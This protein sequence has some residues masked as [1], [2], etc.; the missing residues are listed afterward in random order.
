MLLFGYDKE[1]IFEETRFFELS[2]NKNPLKITHYTVLI[3][4]RADT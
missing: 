1:F 2:Q 3:A 4:L